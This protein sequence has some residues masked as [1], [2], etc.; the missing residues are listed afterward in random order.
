MA[1]REGRGLEGKGRSRSKECRDWRGRGLNPSEGRGLQRKEEPKTGGE[2]SRRPQ[3]GGACNAKLRR[4]AVVSNLVPQTW[5][6]AARR[7]SARVASVPTPTAPSSASVL[8]DIA[9]AQTSPPAWVRGAPG[10]IP[11]PSLLPLLLSH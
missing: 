6:S 11:A 5:T 9:P 1:I 7:T 8:P 2:K 3:R 4:W 10:L